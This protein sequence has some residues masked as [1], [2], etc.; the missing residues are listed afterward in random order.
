MRNLFLIPLLGLTGMGAAVDS[1]A[2]SSETIRQYQF[3]ATLD[4]YDL[5]LRELPMPIAG[6][7]EVLV[8]IRAASLN[9]RDVGMMYDAQRTRGDMSGTIP[10]SDGAG[11]VIAVGDSVTRFSVG[12][13]VVGIFSSSWV[14]GKITPEDRAKV[15]GGTQYGMLS[16]VVVTSEESLVPIPEHL[17][18]EEAATL[19]CAGVTAWNALFKHGQLL[20]DEYVLLE[21]T[22][23]VSTFGLQ[24]A[25]AAGA[26]PIVTSSSNQKL[27]RARTLG[28]IGTVNY[29]ENPD[30]QVEVRRLANDA[31]V[32]HVLE[33]G[34]RDTL[35]KAQEALAMGGH[36][37]I[38]GALSGGLPE[39]DAGSLIMMR[40]TASGV[41]VGSREDFEAMNEF[42]VEHE[43]R[44]VI[45]RTFTFEDAPNAFD[46]MENG[47][48]MGKIVIT[49]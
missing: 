2:Q 23:G 5:V 24:F 14:D 46:F 38:I 43:L 1:Q 11:D 12:D 13:R 6:P 48:Y 31:G 35:L 34:G 32:H 8:R 39:L 9:R 36:I 20:A 18:Y 49:L 21:G 25:A 10:L 16:E 4:G 33:I 30:W 29:R 44:P 17:S 19:P 26:R 40:A 47:D 3:S 15:R 42:I 7:D 28:A 27:E 41:W 22:G 45:D 37:A